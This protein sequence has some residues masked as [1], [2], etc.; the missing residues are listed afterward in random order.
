MWSK[1][2][3]GLFSPKANGTGVFLLCAAGL[4][5]VS[6]VTLLAFHQIADGDLWARL[7]VGAEIRERGFLPRRDFFAFTP[8]LPEWIDHEWGAGLIFY[9]VLRA[10]GSAGLMG[11]KMV[12]ALGCLGILFLV[13]RRAGAGWAAILWLAIPCAFCLLG[14]YVPVVRS[15]AFTYF[16]F[17]LL[18][19]CL[20]EIR[21]R[22]RRWPVAVLLAM[23]LGWANVHGGFVAGLGVIAIYTGLALVRREK[24]RW[25]LLATWLGCFALTLA[26]PYGPN[27]W[28]Y[29]VP[30][31]LHSR[32]AITEWQPL[33]LL[34]QG[35]DPYIGF[36][37]TLLL[38]FFV[39][40]FGWRDLVP[41][42]RNLAGLLVVLVTACLALRSR[43]HQPFFGEACLVFLGPYVDACGKRVQLMQFGR[44]LTS[45]RVAVSLFA[46]YA[47]LAGWILMRCLPQV[48]FQVLAPVGFYP[49]REVDI[50]NRAQAAGNV[51]VPFRWGSYVAWRTYPRIKVSMDGRYETVFPETTFLMNQAFYEKCGADWDRLIRDF[52]VDYVVVEI[53]AT[54]LRPDDL[55]ERGYVLVWQTGQSSALFAR[56]A[57][58]APLLQAARE[59]PPATIDPLDPAI[60]Q[61]WPEQAGSPH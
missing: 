24:A 3:N 28:R 12:L 43:R 8:T 11:L 2:P 27:F 26:N 17:A 61:A 60:P 10:F 7:S 49:V 14:G 20:E 6:F 30:A 52:P 13:A 16:F 41:E 59:L 22:G 46:V 29:L 53:G 4:G 5:V 54:A 39:V 40:V 34:A 21:R 51:A 19:L 37:I 42:K 1:Q 38:A 44:A 9:S 58:A 31:L 47:A 57:V 25:L 35:M 45:R 50:L 33:P 36:R 56:Q 48:S 15:Q 23:T 18:L 55:L 32:S